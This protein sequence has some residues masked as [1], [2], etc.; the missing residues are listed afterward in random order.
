MSDAA[1]AQAPAAGRLT[2]AMR[3]ARFLRRDDVV[4]VLRVARLEG[5]RVI[6]DRTLAARVEVTIGRA[7]DASFVVPEAPP[8]VRVLRATAAGRF[9]ELA[10]GVRGRVVQRDGPV[11]LAAAFAG[12]VRTLQLDDEARGRLELHGVTLL[13]QLVD[14]PPPKVSAQL[15]LSV[16]GA[17]TA[18]IDWRF[19]VLAALS[20]LAHFAFAG[21]V[22]GDWF[23]PAVDEEAETASLVETARARPA[24]ALEQPAPS[25]VDPTVAAPGKPDGPPAAAPTKTASNTGAQSAAH[26]DGTHPSAHAP[27]FSESASK[28]SSDLDTIGVVAIGAFAHDG[29]AT[30][31]V[32]QP[33]ASVIDGQLDELAR[34]KS[35]I[36]IDDGKLKL[37][38]GGQPGGPIGPS[39]NVAFLPATKTTPTETKVVAPDAPPPPPIAEP[40]LAPTS[41]SVVDADAVLARNRWRFS[42][43][44]RKAV[45]ADPSDGGTVRVLVSIGEGGEV[46]SATPTSSTA[47]AGLTQ[48]IARSFTSMRF[49]PPGGSGTGSFTAPIVLQKK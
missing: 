25:P 9:V 42:A 11:D 45:G 19:S 1:H 10:E 48:C 13:F 21:A 29:P 38:P 30:S 18:S 28:L 47:S 12:G 14:A 16:R 32:L 26:G 49:A 34:R 7:L 31:K 40:I 22:N 2:A 27:S 4:R 20:F 37:P 43:C 46:L 41:G 39:S 44:F 17:L 5:G 8:R 36:A 3:A 15:P 24:I 35:A 33:G 23:D 6:D